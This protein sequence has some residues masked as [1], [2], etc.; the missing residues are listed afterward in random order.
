MVSMMTNDCI[1]LTRVPLFVLF[2]PRKNGRFYFWT[3]VQKERPFN[4][5]KAESDFLFRNY[6]KG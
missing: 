4:L 3:Y 5:M 2:F 1:N 6:E